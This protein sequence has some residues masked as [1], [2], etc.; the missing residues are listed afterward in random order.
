M[1][2]KA[3]KVERHRSIRFFRC[4]LGLGSRMVGVEWFIVGAERGLVWRAIVGGGRM[5]L[6]GWLVLVA[7][8]RWFVINGYFSWRSAGGGMTRRCSSCN[9]RDPW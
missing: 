6:I 9:L 5:Y 1:D 4:V 7:R 8:V 3:A 2:Y